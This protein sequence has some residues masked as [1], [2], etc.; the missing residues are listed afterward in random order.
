MI[1][2]KE[3]LTIVI[4]C[5]MFRLPDGSDQFTEEGTMS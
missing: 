2:M 3:L 1:V 4:H 5:P